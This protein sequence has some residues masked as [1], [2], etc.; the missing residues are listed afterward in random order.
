MTFGPPQPKRPQRRGRLIRAS[1][2][3]MSTLLLAGLG[4]AA[5]DQAMR[6]KLTGKWQQ[7]DGKTTWTLKETGDSMHVSSASD[8][9]TV[10]DFDCNTG[11]KEC[12]V[13]SSGHKSK[14]SMWF[15]GAK[16]VELETTGTQTVKRR[17]SVT[18][19]GDTMEIETIPIMPSGSTET[20]HF[21]RV[22][23]EGAKE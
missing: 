7:S 12:A 8:T 22:P 4:F 13:K 10:E 15:N 6:D 21:K 3:T 1:I 14:V 9:Q 11:G 17:F 2:L 18:G 19:T 23:A 5:E 20:A 16:L